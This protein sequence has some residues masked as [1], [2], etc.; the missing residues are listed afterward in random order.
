VNDRALKQELMSMVSA[1]RKCLSAKQVLDSFAA[2]DEVSRQRPRVEEEKMDAAATSSARVVSGARLHTSGFPSSSPSS[3]SKICSI[4][5][6]DEVMV[7]SELVAFAEVQRKRKRKANEIDDYYPKSFA[8]ALTCFVGPFLD[9]CFESDLPLLPALG[10]ELKVSK[11]HVFDVDESQGLSKERRIREQVGR[12]NLLANLHEISE[13]RARPDLSRRDRKALLARLQDQQREIIKGQA[14]VGCFRT[15]RFDEPVVKSH[16]LTARLLGLRES[17]M[18]DI[19]VLDLADGATTDAHRSQ[20]RTSFPLLD[21]LAAIDLGVTNPVV[22]FVGQ[23]LRLIRLGAGCAHRLMFKL[24]ALVGDLQSHASK[25][26]DQRLLASLHQ[27]MDMALQRRVGI[28][29]RLRSNIVRILSCFNIL[30]MPTLTP[31]RSWSHRTRRLAGIV[32]LGTLQTDVATM[33]DQ[34]GIR[35]VTTYDEGTSG[36]YHC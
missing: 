10:D 28:A 20:F 22:V 31:N 4:D 11:G 14:A 21:G 34:R 27:S 35:L 1:C 12:Q 7:E 5:A 17:D 36:I 19:E 2:E 16:V 23:D 30:V 32:N 29:A 13:T 8:K 15:L 25:C 33:C 3:S 6:L 26:T 18:L 9:G 24:D